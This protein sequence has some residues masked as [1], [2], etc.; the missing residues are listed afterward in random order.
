MARVRV[1]GRL[2]A[3]LVVAAALSACEAVDV[4]PPP[5][6]Q[7]SPPPAS[8]A[9]SA[10]PPTASPSPSPSPSPVTVRVD[11]LTGVSPSATGPGAYRY[12]VEAPQ[13][14]GAGT[15]GQ[16][17]DV[18]IRATLQRDIDDFVDDAATGPSP[19]E[20][21][22]TSRTVRLGSRL[23][24]LRVDCT[25]RLAG[26]QPVL[27]ARAFNCDLAGG[28]VLALQDLFGAGSTYLDVL[29]QAAR[30]QLRSRLPAG[31]DRMLDDGTAPI[32]DN[33]KTF[34]L[35]RDSLVIVL[36]SRYQVAGASALLEVPV[37]YDDVHRLLAR[38][39]NDL[40]AG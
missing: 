14:E 37:P 35:A 30:S 7:V 27:T 4:Q 40:L 5:V 28:R 25:V 2:L 21:T 39:V 12:R 20:L 29:S 10:P 19:S 33:F 8:P 9:A 38:G 1:G 34:L 22:C 17:L 32:A 24:V 3:A 16:T 18:V 31:D 36:P 23:A 11:A 6:A 26:A 13:L 15:R